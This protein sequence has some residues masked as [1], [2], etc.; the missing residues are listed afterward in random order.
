MR[1]LVGNDGED[2]AGLLTSRELIHHLVLLISGAP[3]PA[4]EGTDP[5][6]GLL[7]HDLLLEEVQRGHGQV[8]LLLEVLSEAGNLEMHVA[9]HLTLGGVEVARQQLDEGGL[10][11]WIIFD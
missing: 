10:C 3:V 9:L 2:D 1:L 7:R 8:Q 11:G 5:L 6:D 4:E